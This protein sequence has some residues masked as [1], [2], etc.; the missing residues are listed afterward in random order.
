M[1]P[2]PDAISVPHASVMCIS[3]AAVIAAIFIVVTVL[4]PSGNRGFVLLI[5]NIEILLVDTKK[6]Q[7]IRLGIGHVRG[8]CRAN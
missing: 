8:S 6:M 1:P 7:P 5:K 3:A 2:S 4:L